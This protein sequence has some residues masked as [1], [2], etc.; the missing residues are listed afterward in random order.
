[1]GF[2][3]QAF[4]GAQH[5]S[6]YNGHVSPLFGY[7]GGSLPGAEGG[8]VADPGSRSH[9]RTWIRIFFLQCVLHH[10]ALAHQSLDLHQ[11]GETSTQCGDRY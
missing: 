2:D 6:S 5:V 10:V 11:S 3:W 4:L 7:W 9:G 1:M 8:E